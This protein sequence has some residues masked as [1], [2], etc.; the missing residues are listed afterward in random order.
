MVEIKN[1]KYALKDISVREEYWVGSV[2]LIKAMYVL[3]ATTII[4]QV[5]QI[6]VSVL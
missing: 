4:S 1:V 2:F 3:V 5:K 6:K